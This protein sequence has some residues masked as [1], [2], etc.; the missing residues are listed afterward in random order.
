MERNAIFGKCL[1]SVKPNAGE[2]QISDPTMQ[3]PIKVIQLI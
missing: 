1:G 2:I 3:N